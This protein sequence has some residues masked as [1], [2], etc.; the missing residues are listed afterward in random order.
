MTRAPD[1]SIYRTRTQFKAAIESLPQTAPRT[2]G[3][4]IDAADLAYER[5]DYRGTE[6]EIDRKEAAWDDA[7]EALRA[8]LTVNLGL[9]KEQIRALGGILL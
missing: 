4:L 2:L 1:I 8:H 3:E 6:E 5:N 9:T 7:E